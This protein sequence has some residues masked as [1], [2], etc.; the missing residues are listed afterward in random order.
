MRKV[1]SQLMALVMVV[2]LSVNVFGQD[3]QPSPSD[4]TS[5]SG[6]Q[7]VVTP[8]PD[9]AP[10]EPVAGAA[11]G[12]G[13]VGCGGQ[14]MS[15]NYGGVVYGGGC[16]SCGSAPMSTGCGSCMTGGCNMVSSCNTCNT[17]NSCDRNRVLVRRDNCCN[18]ANDCGR[19]T[20]LNRNNCCQ[21]A[22]TC[23]NSAPS[24]NTCNTCNAAPVMNTCNTCNTCNA[25]PV[26]SNCNTC[27]TAPVMNT[28]CNSTPVM[29]TGCYNTAPV[30]TACNTGCNMPV[31]TCGSVQP[32]RVARVQM[33]QPRGTFVRL[34]G[35]R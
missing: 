23:C 15:T 12:S 8:A 22:S 34:G 27:N 19:R 29:S 30:A 32:T 35:R 25:T 24:C 18:V 17:C 20:I 3:N 26:V 10:V 21:P 11:V 14:V 9:Q 1:L 28:C 5:T 31:A 13:C 7:T 16:S 6:V 33:M 2:G 4:A